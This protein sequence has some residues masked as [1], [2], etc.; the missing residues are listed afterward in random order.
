MM[1]DLRANVEREWKQ[2]NDQRRT[3][4]MEDIPESMIRAEIKKSI[5]SF[6]S[7]ARAVE[8]PEHLERLT[9]LFYR[10]L[11]PMGV[12]GGI[13]NFVSEIELGGICLLLDYG[14]PADPPL[15][16]SDEFA[17][18]GD[19][20]SLAEIEEGI[21]RVETRV[22]PDHP[23]A[24]EVVGRMMSLYRRRHDVRERYH[25]GIEL[26]S[27]FIQPGFDDWRAAVAFAQ[28]THVWSN[29]RYVYSPDGMAR[30]NARRYQRFGLT[31]LDAVK[32]VEPGALFQVEKVFGEF[33]PSYVHGDLVKFKELS[34]YAQQKAAKTFFQSVTACDYDLFRRE[35][36]CSCSTKN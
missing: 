28:Y 32:V 27:S 24:M 10:N 26:P 2:L 12:F 21:E 17:D 3:N 18:H 29:K 34:Y 13:G 9:N 8:S 19:Y 25:A 14:T 33:A 30:I 11:P 20:A 6:D 31:S 22:L 1:E 7:L 4:N 36:K 5:L 15:V 35:M 16:R 23:K